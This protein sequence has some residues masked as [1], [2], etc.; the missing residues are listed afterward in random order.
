MLKVRPWVPYL[1]C[2]PLVALL[3]FIFA[4]PIVR[5]V[6]FSTRLVR[7]ASGPV[8]RARQLPLRLSTTRP[9]A[10][11]SSTARLLLLAVPVLLAIS[12]LVVGAAVR[13]AARRGSIYRS[14]L[15]LPYILAVPIV[16]IVGQL[17]VPAARRRQR[18]ARAVG[19]ESLAIDWIGQRALRADDRRDR[20]RLARGR[21]RH[22]ALPGAA[23]DARRRASSR[24]RA[25]TARL[26]AAALR[27]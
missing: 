15:F 12:I 26:V 13:A 11:R 7:G 1:Y 14:V 18:P 2:A 17:H 23:D 10:T 27:T 4:Y 16:G 22:R 3:A 24:P 9:S 8:H 25:S 5:V 21:L 20:D 19:L 6:D